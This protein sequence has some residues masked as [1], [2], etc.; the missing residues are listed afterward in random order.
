MS[1]GLPLECDDVKCVI[2]PYEQYE[3]LVRRSLTAPKVRP[4]LS[5]KQKAK[6][7]DHM[8][9]QAVVNVSRRES[10]SVAQPVGE[11]VERNTMI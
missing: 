9:A 4:A 7:R 1:T 6:F 5:A 8:A 2:C 10:Y 3:E 11:M